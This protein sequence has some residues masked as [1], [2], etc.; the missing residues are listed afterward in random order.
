MEI[1]WLGSVVN[2][3]MVNRYPAI[4]PAGNKWQLRLIRSF[5][6][7]PNVD[8]LCIGHRLERVFPFG[9]LFVNDNHW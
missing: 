9:R 4:S 3:E 7:L 6:E 1:I 2:E 5:L 8:V